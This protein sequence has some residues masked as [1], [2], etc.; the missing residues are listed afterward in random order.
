MAIDRIEDLSSALVAMAR[1]GLKPRDLIKA[2]LRAHPS[3]TKKQ[4]VRAAFHT[5]VSE[6]RVDAASAAAIY[7]LAITERASEN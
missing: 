3:A 1:P 6:T 2:V 7:D 5:L 4:V